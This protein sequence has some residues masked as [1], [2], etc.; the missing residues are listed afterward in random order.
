MNQKEIEM[1]VKLREYVVSAYKALDG[2]QPGVQVDHAMIK[3]VDVAFTLSSIA[4][5]I[6]DILGENVQYK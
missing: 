1:L 3:Q 4:R 5:S 2:A 6:E